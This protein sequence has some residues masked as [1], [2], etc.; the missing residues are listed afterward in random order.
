VK[1]DIDSP[2]EPVRCLFARSS[3]FASTQASDPVSLTD[4]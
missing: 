1:S 2:N 3:Y 4:T